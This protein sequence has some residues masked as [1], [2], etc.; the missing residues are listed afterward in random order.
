VKKVKD[1][2]GNGWPFEKRGGNAVHDV[3]IRDLLRV[4]KRYT[5]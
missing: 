1:N 2:G 3:S 5:F 4:R